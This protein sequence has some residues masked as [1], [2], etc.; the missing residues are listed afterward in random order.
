M[1]RPKVGVGIVV[2]KDG[3]ILMG[4]RKN[5]HGEGRWA[6][7]GGHLEFGETPGAC[8]RRELAEET[9]IIPLSQKQGPWTNDIM[10]NKHYITLWMFVPQFQGTPQLLE[11]HN[12]DGW[13][14][15]EWNA[16]P[17]PLF[18]SVENLIKGVGIDQLNLLTL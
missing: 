3:K 17:K 6:P 18:Q 7:P 8:V 13:E 10:E 12:C 2:I 11:P 15:F 14:W 1:E 4:K 9:G 5:A 16:L